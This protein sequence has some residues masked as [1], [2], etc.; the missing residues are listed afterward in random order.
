MIMPPSGPMELIW[1]DWMNQISTSLEIS[2]LLGLFIFQVKNKEIVFFTASPTE[3]Y[4][5]P[6]QILAFQPV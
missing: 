6:F 5:P 2:I 1:I 3:V 4:H